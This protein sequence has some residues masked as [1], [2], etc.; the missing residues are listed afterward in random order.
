MVNL[1]LNLL[2]MY[3]CNVCKQIFAAANGYNGGLRG[4]VCVA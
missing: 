2:C 1:N 3:V 4:T